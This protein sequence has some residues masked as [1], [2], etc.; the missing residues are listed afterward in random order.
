MQMQSDMSKQL[1]VEVDD[2][3]V[4]A[5]LIIVGDDQ[6]TVCEDR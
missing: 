4:R 2:V 1:H 6:I 5:N 3:A